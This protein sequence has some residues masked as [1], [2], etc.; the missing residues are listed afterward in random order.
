[1]C[2]QVSAEYSSKLRKRLTNPNLN[3]NPNPILEGA[4]ISGALLKELAEENEQLRNENERL[5][6][7]EKERIE[8]D[9]QHMKAMRTEELQREER[10]VT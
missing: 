8:A 7:K 1:L 10:A 2:V 6:S 4:R 3:P 9:R 5:R